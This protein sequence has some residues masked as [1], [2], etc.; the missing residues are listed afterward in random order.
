[1][2]LTEMTHDTG[3]STNLCVDKRYGDPVVVEQFVAPVTKFIQRLQMHNG[4]FI[5]AQ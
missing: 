2:F 3:I 1:M 4:N 5:N